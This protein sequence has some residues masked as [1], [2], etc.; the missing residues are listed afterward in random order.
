[1]AERE[2]RGVEASHENV[3]RGGEGSGER[4]EAEARRQNR[5]KR[6]KERGG[7]KQPLLY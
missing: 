7:G 3:E 6:V 1:M 4:G 2:S 5:S